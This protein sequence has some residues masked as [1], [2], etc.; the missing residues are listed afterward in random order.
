MAS[1]LGFAKAHLKPKGYF[2]F[3]SLISI[4]GFLN[5]YDTDSI[6]AVI[7]MPSFSHTISTLPPLLRGFTVSLIMMTGAIP[8]IFAG[9]LADRFGQLSVVYAGALVFTLGTAMEGGSGKLGVFLA[10]RALAGYITE[11]APSSQR[12]KLVSMPQ[13]LA[14]VGRTPFIIQAI[15]GAV[16]AG[17][18]FFLPGSPRWLMDHGR[19]EEA[20]RS[21]E[22]LG[23]EREEAEKDILNVRLGTME[24]R[25]MNGMEFLGIFRKEYRERT[26]LGLFILGMVQLCGI[27]GVLYYAPT[28]FAQAGLPSGTSSFLASGVSAIVMLLISIPAFLLA[29]TWG[30]RT[31]VITG[32]LLLSTC[33]FTIGILYATDS[34]HKDGSGRWLVIVL[35]FVFA[36]GYC[37]TWGV[38]G[39]IYASEIQPSRTRGGASGVA[40]G[41]G[42]LTNWLVAFTTPIFLANSSY[43]AYFLFG[44]FSPFALLWL[45]VKMPETRGLP[46]ET[47]QEG[48]KALATGSAGRGLGSRR[49][50]LRRIFA[51]PRLVGEGVGGGNVDGEERELREGVLA[52]VMRVEVG[53]V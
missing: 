27:D 39:K 9:Q 22:R 45:A 2:L 1:F 38:V 37:G 30:R 42:F 33:M 53:S 11:I 12:G 20:L 43:G 7:E 19:R 23:I 25:G 32:G 36:V 13:L 26:M 15:F 50:R 17:S 31:S 35:I 8:G 52:G 24:E 4:G 41:L 34:V 49:V 47:I 48:F 10:G 46:L 40:Q 16:L 44:S 21:L 28:L 5:G 18:C 6:G 51:G 14:A 29:D 3:A